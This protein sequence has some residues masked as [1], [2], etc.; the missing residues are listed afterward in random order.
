MKLILE[1]W[2]RFLKEGISNTK[3][4]YGNNFIYE[5]RKYITNTED[6]LPE[7]VMNY[8]NYN[9]WSINPRTHYF[10]KGIYF[11]FLSRE[12]D[13]G[14]S[15]ETFAADAPWANIAKVNYEKAVVLKKGHSRDF[16]EQDLEKSIKLL[17][18]IYGPLPAL[19]PKGEKFSRSERLNPHFSKLGAVISTLAKSSSNFN[20]ILHEIGYD[21]ILD[22]DGDLLPIE[23]CQ[24]VQTWTGG[25][26]YK[27]SLKTGKENIRKRVKRMFD[28]LR[29]YKDGTLNITLEE[30]LE[31]LSFFPKKGYYEYKP[32]R[33]L[34]YHKILVRKINFKYD[35]NNMEEWLRWHEFH[36]LQRYGDEFAFMMYENPTTPSFVWEHLQHA[37]WQ[38]SHV[39]KMAK[40]RLNETDT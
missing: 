3:P 16:S 7:Y 27:F 5:V 32:D 14:L 18:N 26:A 10:P 33:K 34:D 30:L 38:Y 12:C 29:N 25:A 2:N 36:N 20:K 37:P 35:E 24:G 13:Y 23:S 19:D 11:Y 22:F 6:G 8:S 40:E 4:L 9:Q 28:G 1:R 31:V 17:K 21:I 15:N 39:A